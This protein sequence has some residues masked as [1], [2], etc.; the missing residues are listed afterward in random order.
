MHL[1]YRPMG[2]GVNWGPAAPADGHVV[3]SQ[4]FHRSSSDIDRPSGLPTASNHVLDRDGLALEGPGR[5]D[6]PIDEGRRYGFWEPAH[7]QS[8]LQRQRLVAAGETTKP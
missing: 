2:V 1:R 6:P 3:L 5:I 8:S 4:G 7:R